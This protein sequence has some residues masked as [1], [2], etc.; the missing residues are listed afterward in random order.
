[1]MHLCE[2]CG[3]SPAVGWF[4]RETTLPLWLYDALLFIYALSILFFVYF[5]IFRLIKRKKKRGVKNEI[6]Q[7]RGNMQKKPAYGDLER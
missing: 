5:I 7:N 6:Q 4:Y 3:S 1:M 2:K